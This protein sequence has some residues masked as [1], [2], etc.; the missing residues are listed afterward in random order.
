MAA[1]PR[2]GILHR[3]LFRYGLKKDPEEV[4]AESRDPSKSLKKSLG[5][6]DLTILGV[7][8]IIG[9]GIFVLAGL[10]ATMAGPY[11]IF[12][13]ILAG[14]VCA[15]AGLAYAEL[16]STIPTSGSAY[17]YTYSA[18]GE[19][20]AWT[21][22]WALVLE[23]AVGSAAVAIGW[24][25]NFDALLRSFFG[26]DLPTWAT[27][28]YFGPVAGGIVN[29]PA[30]IIVLFIT[31]VLVVGSKASAKLAGVFV[32][33]K[34]AIL[35]LV[36]GLGLFF[37]SADNLTLAPPAPTEGAWYAILGAPGVIIGAA[38]II[39]FAY[40]GFDAVSTTAEETKNPKKDLP[41]GIL[42]SLFICTA[43]YI[44]AT[45]VLVGMVPY[46]DMMPDCASPDLSADVPC[47]AGNGVTPD[48]AG[49][50][51][52]EPFGYAFEA[53]G[54]VWAANLIRAGAIIGITSVLMVLLMGG[55]RVFF[56]LARD[57]LLPK[58]WSKVHEKF[59]TPARTTIGTGLAVAL[60]AGFGTLGLAGQL[61]NIGTLYAFTL[62][63]IGV[64][65]LRYTKPHLERPFRVP[66]SIGRF[67]ILALLGAI[68]CVGL[69][70]SLDPLT[71]L[72][73]FGWM[74]LGL[75]VYAVYG[76]RKSKLFGHVGRDGRDP[77]P[78]PQA[79]SEIVL[80]EV[81]A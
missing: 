67:P 56:A 59:G 79:D 2:S 76:I 58:S 54:I 77:R 72:G 62:V 6:L 68:L 4:I 47:Y 71:I 9:A 75:M 53:N 27:N 24:S 63:C 34:V 26:V 1:E 23:Y 43:L 35:F 39:F 69:M 44:L 22:G 5:A 45:T 42:G 13:F 73:F 41:I 49:E 16:S 52:G 25:A 40:I 65:V 38:A 29:L 28:S 17:A 12:S 78:L 74:G 3:S 21:L 80:E 18:V 70:V 11:I 15:L 36:I 81:K 64:I 20:V 50:R 33:A 46:S 48:Q 57:G 51:L 37:V 10:G 19:A 66:L 14:I 7:G 32:V 31:A 30:M 61:T 55:P 8:A 60:V